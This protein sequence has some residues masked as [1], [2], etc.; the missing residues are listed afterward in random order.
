MGFVPYV[1]SRSSLLKKMDF[2]G[3]LEEVRIFI[4]YN[5]LDKNLQYYN[6]SRDIIMIVEF[7]LS[8]LLKVSLCSAM[9]NL[10][11]LFHHLNCVLILGR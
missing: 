7:R 3:R 9:P 2:A 4:D 5:G 6:K 10:S 1:A 8:R 11:P